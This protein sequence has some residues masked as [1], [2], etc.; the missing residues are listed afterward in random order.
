MKKYRKNK[1]KFPKPY[2]LPQLTNVKQRL[3]ERLFEFCQTAFQKI[4]TA[5]QF[6]ET[7]FGKIV[8]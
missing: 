5:F 3:T 1:N 4:K 7:P 8:S 2:S 6:F